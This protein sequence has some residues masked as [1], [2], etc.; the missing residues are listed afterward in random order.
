[1][2]KRKA[3]PGAVPTQEELDREEANKAGEAAREKAE[4]KRRAN[5][6]KQARFRKSMIEKGYRVVKHWEGPAVPGMV[7]PWGDTL[8]PLIQETSAGV[9]E[10]DTAIR[11]AVKK[12]LASFFVSMRGENDNM[13][14]EAWAAYKDIETLLSPLGY[15]G[16]E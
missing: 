14:K 13:S 8:P 12:M 2:A 11:E 16:K 7:K 3:Q 15:K 10:R 5:A 4:K 9:C 6:E 1:M